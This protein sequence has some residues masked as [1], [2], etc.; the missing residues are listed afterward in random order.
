MEILPENDQYCYCCGVKNE[1]GL[2]LK[3]SYPHKG[4]SLTET[5]IPDYYTG[6]KNVVHG[7]YLAMVLD[8][9]M[10]HAC[11]SIGKSAFTAEITVR[12]HK[13]AEVGEKIYVH[14]K[15]DKLRTKIIDTSAEIHNSDDT[16]IAE[17][18]AKFM[19]P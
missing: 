9:A 15:I 18:K 4:S 1:K 14:A 13:P 2:H 11:G 7:G 8:E 5:T 12:Y 16:L 19:V 17:S 10:A 3:F 6:W